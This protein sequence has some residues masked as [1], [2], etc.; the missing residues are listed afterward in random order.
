MFKHLH[1]RVDIF[2]IPPN[3]SRYNQ[4][5]VSLQL[6]I[7]LTTGAGDRPFG[8]IDRTF[9]VEVHLRTTLAG[10]S[11]HDIRGIRRVT[12]TGGLTE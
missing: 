9:D 10:A 6:G 7:D 3:V 4:C 2:G 8:D 11:R 12:V 1:E 5:A